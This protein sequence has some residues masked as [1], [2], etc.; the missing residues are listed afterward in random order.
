VLLSSETA[1]GGESER[2]GAGM[3]WGRGDANDYTGLTCE[4]AILS[5]IAGAVPGRM[6]ER[7][8]ERWIEC[9]G[10]LAA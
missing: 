8:C 6:D 5:L 4:L 3:P 9:T 1:W 2:V 10:C 7:K